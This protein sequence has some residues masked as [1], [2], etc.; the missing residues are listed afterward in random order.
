[1]K[2][3]LQTVLAV[4]RKLL[5]LV[6]IAIVAVEIYKYA[7]PPVHVLVLALGLLLIYAGAWRPRR[8]TMDRRANSVLRAEINHFVEL[9]RALYSHRTNGDSAAIHET[10]LALRRS[11]ERIIKKAALY[12]AK[13]GQDEDEEDPTEAIFARR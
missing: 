8:T 1:M 6:G 11:V 7:V 3:S 5:P 2:L 9:V 12:R 10:K 13:G 4:L